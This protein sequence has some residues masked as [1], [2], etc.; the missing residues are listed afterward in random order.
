MRGVQWAAAHYLLE[1]ENA[2]PWAPAGAQD[3]G[4][5]SSRRLVCNPEGFELTQPLGLLVVA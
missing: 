4:T 5:G 2:P 1:K 3:A